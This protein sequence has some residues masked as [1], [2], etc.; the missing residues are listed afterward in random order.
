MQSLAVLDSLKIGWKIKDHEIVAK[1][2]PFLLLE[3]Y[4]VF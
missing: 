4:L 2:K 3:A 1:P